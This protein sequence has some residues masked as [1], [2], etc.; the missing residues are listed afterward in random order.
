[1]DGELLRNLKS[2]SEM[3][4]KEIGEQ[5]DISRSMLIFVLK[6]Q[7]RLG[8]DNLQRQVDLAAAWSSRG[9]FNSPS[10]V[11]ALDSTEGSNGTTDMMRRE[12]TDLRLRLSSDERREA[13]QLDIVR[14]LSK[15]VAPNRT[16]HGHS[17]ASPPAGPAYGTNCGNSRSK[18]KAG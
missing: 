15:L 10:K 14:N 17:P 7:K 4:W 18:A 1:M 5:L 16:G 9:V 6:G 12:I 8:R 2:T 11:D 13:E 3:N